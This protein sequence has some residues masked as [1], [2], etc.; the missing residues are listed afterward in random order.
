MDSVGVVLCLITI[1]FVK[2]SALT[3][4]IIGFGCYLM[5]IITKIYNA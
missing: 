2:C 5:N 1:A 3:K 4:V